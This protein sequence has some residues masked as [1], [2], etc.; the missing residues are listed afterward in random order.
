MDALRLK[1]LAACL[2]LGLAVGAE[3]FAP[4]AG[5]AA[6][7]PAPHGGITIPVTT[8]ENA[9]AGSLREAMAAAG[10]G[11][12]LDLTALTCGSI[13]LTT[14]QVSTAAANL[15]IK[16]PG[17]DALTIDASYA[18]LYV[19]R[20]IYHGGT[21]TL[22]IYDVTITDARYM[23]S[24]SNGGCVH[25]EGSVYLMR[26]VVTDCW[27][28]PTGAIDHSRGGAIFARGQVLAKYSAIEDSRASSRD[29]LDARGGG[30]YA[31][32]G[33]LAKYSTIDGNVAYAAPGGRG[34]GGG[35]MT[36]GG[37]LI[38]NSTIS[39]NT[40]MNVGGVAVNA[41][42]TSSE[43][44]NSTISGNEATNIIGGLITFGPLT[45]D[46]ST[47]AFNRAAV[48]HCSQYGYVYCNAGMQVRD[49]TDIQSSIVANNYGE[50]TFADISVAAS[51][52][53]TG[54]NILTRAS[55]VLLPGDTIYADPLLYPLANNGGLTRTH[56]LRDGSPAIDAG[57]NDQTFASDQ[58]G[59]GFARTVGADTDIGAFERQAALDGDAIF[60]N[61]FDP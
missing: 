38:A 43:I 17:A 10:D 4:I 6:S 32:G 61:G 3:L 35:V 20:A 55:A 50:L 36:T 30:I 49:A 16:G 12:T 21:G 31:F 34:L 41:E 25:S 7:T 11:D 26:S 22:S 24:D 57:N 52:A 27:L 59:T 33:V 18:Q 42:T 44:R 47:I 13:T 40:A 56:A 48:R 46:N 23:G 1:P 15:A 29:G 45:V 60:A 37:V 28:D 54:A 5:R 39:G 58:R 19:H 51:G 14:G 9:G 8:C 53:V 2:S